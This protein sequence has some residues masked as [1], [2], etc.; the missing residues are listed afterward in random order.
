MKGTQKAKKVKGFTDVERQA[1]KDRVQELKA[2]KEDG[3]SAVLVGDLRWQDGRPSQQR[4]QACEQAWQQSILRTM[5]HGRAI[6]STC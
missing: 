5:G 3:E 1:I 2:S 4:Q 6:I